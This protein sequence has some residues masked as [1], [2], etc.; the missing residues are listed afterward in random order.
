MNVPF[1]ALFCP[2]FCLA[3]RFLPELPGKQ[4]YTVESYMRRAHLLNCDGETL[5][6]YDN[7]TRTREGYEHQKYGRA[8]GRLTTAGD[9]IDWKGDGEIHIVQTEM[10]GVGEKH[11]AQRRRPI[12]ADCVRH[13]AHVLDR[14]GH[15]VA[16]FPI[17]DDPMC[18]R[19]ARVTGSRAQ[20]IVVVG[21]RNSRIHIY[22]HKV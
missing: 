21:H 5:W 10:G 2:L 22:T 11:N 1:S 6:T 9:L 8:I 7:F 16:I 15:P 14:N 17:E 3:A 19:A 13:F 20:D 12:P 4:V 18:A